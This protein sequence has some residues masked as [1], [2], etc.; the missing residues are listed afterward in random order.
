MQVT[1][2]FHY[3]RSWTMAEQL[4]PIDAAARVAHRH[5]LAA[6]GL[7]LLLGVAALLSFSPAD[8]A[9]AG[10]ALWMLLPVTI[11]ITAAAL[12]G[13]GKRVDARALDA[14]HH[15][16]AQAGEGARGDGGSAVRYRERSGL[17]GSIG[18]LRLPCSPW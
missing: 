10:R 3:S 18:L 4:T 17:S 9:R 6:L 15:P 1:L 13:M 14:V 5:L 7:V 8:F 11:T 16:R 12:H 2:Q